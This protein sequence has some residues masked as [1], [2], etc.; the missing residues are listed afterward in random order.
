MFGW[1]SFVFFADPDGNRWAVQQLPPRDGPRSSG[2]AQCLPSP[3]PS[4]DS[5][6]SVRV[7]QRFLFYTSGAHVAQRRRV[8]LLREHVPVLDD[9]PVLVETEG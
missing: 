5:A 9:L 8:D 7:I 4:H 1:G 2:R 3:G 6:P